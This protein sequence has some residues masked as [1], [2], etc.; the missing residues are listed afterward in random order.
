MGSDQKRALLAIILSGLVLYGYQVYFAPKNINTNKEQAIEKNI[1]LPKSDIKTI[2][3]KAVTEIAVSSEN[4]VTFK[5]L[6]NDKYGVKVSSDL[7]VYDFRNDKQDVLVTVGNYNPLELFLKTDGSAKKIFF[8]FATQDNSSELYGESADKVYKAFLKLN[9]FGRLSFKIVSNNKLSNYIFRLNSTTLESGSM[10]G[11]RASRDFLVYKKEDVERFRVG[12]DDAGDGS[13]KWF[14][15]DHKQ[16]LFATVLKK[17]TVLKYAG[18]E[19]GNLVVNTINPTNE[20]EFDV[21]FLK[22]DYDDLVALGDNLDLSVDFGILGIIAVPI[23]RGLQFFYRVIPNYGVG[24]ILLTL[25]M[26]LLTFPLQYKSFKSMKKMQ[27]LQPD[28]KKIK[29]KYQDDPQRVQRETMELF[30]KNKANPISGCLPMLL[31]MPVFFAFYRVLYNSVELIGAPFTGW[32][33]D[34]SLK[35][36]YYVLPVLVAISFFVQQKLTPTT[37]V[38][39]SQKKIMMLMPLMFCFFMKD[40]PAGLNLYIL[41]STIFGVAQQYFVM[42]SVD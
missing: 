15:L 39:S 3:K 40:M 16:S 2:E 9:E 36:P 1:E 10:F 14:G 25:V 26:R 38:D 33:Y 32:I 29:E 37:G 20:L 19:A 23:L 35:D 8:N 21:V 17:K 27:K 6:T 31:Q 34:L 5:T 18:L 22:K 12:D 13:T 28:L 4:K 30:K 11:S 24:I 41:V 7:S 42:R